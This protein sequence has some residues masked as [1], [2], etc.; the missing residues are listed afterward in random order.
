M[1]TPLNMARPVTRTVG[2]RSFIRFRHRS[3]VLFPQPDGPM[4]DVIRCRCIP[5]ETLRIALKLPYQR[6]RSWTSMAFSPLNVGTTE[7]FAYAL[8]TEHSSERGRGGRPRAH[9]C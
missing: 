8:T 7:P 1:S 9:S 5:R 2:T 6:E 4:S 3:S